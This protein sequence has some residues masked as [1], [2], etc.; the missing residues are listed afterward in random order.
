MYEMH[1]TVR[2]VGLRALVLVLC[3]VLPATGCVPTAVS[4]ADEARARVACAGGRAELRA[5]SSADD[6]SRLRTELRIETP[7]PLPSW[8]VVLLHERTLVLN[9][10]RRTDGSRRK[11]RVRLTLPDWPGR[12]TVTARFT[13]RE[14]RTCRLQVTI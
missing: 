14:G 2:A 10:V 1:P 13:T 5:E 3:V 12:E 9:G 7:R 11:L 4:R 6:A 8:R